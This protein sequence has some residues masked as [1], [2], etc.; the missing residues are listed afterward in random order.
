MSG[1]HGNFTG[2]VK[3]K[4]TLQAKQVFKYIKMKKKITSY[5][6]VFEC[7]VYLLFVFNKWEYDSYTFLLPEVFPSDP[8]KGPKASFH[9]SDL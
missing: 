4:Y 6:L 1:V 2:T 7:F 9:L 8:P 3:T 5:S